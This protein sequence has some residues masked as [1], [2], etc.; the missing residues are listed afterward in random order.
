MHV[1]IFSLPSSWFQEGAGPDFNLP[2]RPWEMLGHWREFMF[3]FGGQEISTPS[4]WIWAP[5]CRKIVPESFWGKNEKRLT[6]KVPHFTRAVTDL[7]CLITAHRMHATQPSR[8]I[9][10]HKWYRDLKFRAIND[11]LDDSFKRLCSSLWLLGILE[12]EN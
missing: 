2:I 3:E 6:K 8:C 4:A 1:D 11:E 10:I 5:N 9:H 12:R 7:I